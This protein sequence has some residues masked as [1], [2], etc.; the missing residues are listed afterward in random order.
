MANRNNNSVSVIDTATNTVVATAPVGATPT[1]VT[2]NPIG[3]FTYVANSASNTVSVISSATNTV[4]ATIPVGSSP[5]A[6]AFGVRDP[7]AGLIAQVQAL[8]TAGSL[9]QNQG[10]G[11]IDKLNQVIAKLDNEQRAAAC[12]QLSA[13][14]NQVNAF[15]NDGSLTSAQGQ[16]LIDAVNAIKTGLGC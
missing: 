11:L 3:T 1:G 9:T 10:D 5:L 7:I 13:F 15:I 14:V 12:N 8:V 16:A 2:V 6:I 4:V